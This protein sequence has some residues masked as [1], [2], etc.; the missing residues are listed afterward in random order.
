M[1][2]MTTHW[3]ST[4]GMVVLVGLLASGAVVAQESMV[5]APSGNVGINNANP[6][7][8]LD[9]IAPTADIDISSFSQDKDLA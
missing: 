6:S 1:T 9:V 2:R 7:A 4:M 8:R 3:I 5:I